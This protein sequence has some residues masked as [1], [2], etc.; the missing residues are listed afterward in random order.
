MDNSRWLLAVLG[1]FLRTATPALHQQQDDQ[2]DTL[3]MLFMARSAPLKCQGGAVGPPSG[4]ADSGCMHAFVLCMGWCIIRSM[5]LWL[6]V[7]WSATAPFFSGVPCAF[8]C[9]VVVLRTLRPMLGSEKT[10]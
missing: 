10:A 7:R 5:R 1:T 8:F 9:C 3:H 6:V 2:A 4:A